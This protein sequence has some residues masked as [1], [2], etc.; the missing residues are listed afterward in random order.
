MA[1]KRRVNKF[2]LRKCNELSAKF[3]EGVDADL[4]SAML[5]ES[6]GEKSPR[7]LPIFWMS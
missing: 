6:Q 4:M 3:G 5:K 1:K 2:R 7:S